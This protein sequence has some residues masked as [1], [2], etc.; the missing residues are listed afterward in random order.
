VKRVLLLAWVIVILWTARTPAQAPTPRVPVP[1]W[2]EQA[3]AAGTR[4]TSG[5]PGGNYWQWHPEYTIRA[6]LDPTTAI[7]E[8]SETIRVR[9]TGP[10]PLTELRLRLDQ[11]LFRPDAA[12]ELPVPAFMHTNGIERLSVRL[13]GVAVRVDNATGTLARIALAPPVPSGATIVLEISWRFRVPADPAG[14]AMRM[15][16]RDHVLFQV[17]QWYPRLAMYDDL[18]G[19][20]SSEH[21]GEWEF[22]NHFGSF[23]VTLDLP[24]GWIAGATGTLQNSD[25]VLTEA[26][27]ARLTAAAQV[28]AT[29]RI[30][31]PGLEDP[32]RP[33]A[34]RWHFAAANVSDFAWAASNRFAWD[35]THAT[36]HG[37]PPVPI[38]ILYDPRGSNAS[39]YAA[40][41][42]SARAIVQR[43][44]TLWLPYPWAS[45]TIVDGPEKGME[46][47]MFVMSEPGLYGHE[48]LHQWWP[49]S[50]G[51]D[52][53]R[54]AFMDEGFTSWA[55]GWLTETSTAPPA[56]GSEARP[57]P[58]PFILP[59]GENG[60]A[61]PYSPRMLDALSRLAGR[62]ETGAAMAAYARAWQFKHPSPWDFMR[63]MDRALGRNLDAFW[64]EW[65]FASRATAPAAT[66]ARVRALT[67]PPRASRSR[68]G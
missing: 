63:F 19:W 13:D 29:T 54:Y 24:A 38:H 49:M 48:I 64:H 2:M 18:R 65:L 45:L 47:P 17:A 36:L 30:A 26:V 12:K 3:Y 31:G 28:E 67:E 62:E 14:S 15:G 9:H 68:R 22:Y 51:T 43:A 42:P 50:I 11:N 58:V 53:R 5:S 1:E 21:L 10:V 7:I 35:V 52:E 60:K 32:L 57:G 61:L 46:Y 33:G 23:D 55:A 4:S 6:A 41:G 59:D 20:D 8:G 25:T 44:S 27:R 37:R 34:H 39:A 56:P 16:H 40:S 66:H